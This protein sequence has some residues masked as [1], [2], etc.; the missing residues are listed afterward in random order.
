MHVTYLDVDFISC[1]LKHDI[2]LLALYIVKSYCYIVVSPFNI[3]RL[4]VSFT[5]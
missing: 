2:F 4:T 3:Y 1:V 5:L